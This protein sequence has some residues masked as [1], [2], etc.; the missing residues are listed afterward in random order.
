MIDPYQ[1]LGIPHG[2]TEEEIKKAYRKKAK[3]YHPDL[4]PDDPVAAQKMNEVNEAYDMLKNPEKYERKRAQEKQQSSY[5]QNYYDNSGQRSYGSGQS[6]YG[7]GQSS[8]GSGYGSDYGG[9]GYYSGYGGFNFE[10]FF[11][12]FG[13]DNQQQYGPRPQSNDPAEMVR[14]VQAI[15]AGR[16]TEAIRILS[17]MTSNQ[18]NARWYYLMALAYK[19]NGDHSQAF[20]MIQKAIQLEPGNQTY[21]IL[22]RQYSRMTQSGTDQYG[23]GSGGSGWPMNG[24]RIIGL[25]AVLFFVL[26]YLLRCGSLFFW[27]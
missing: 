3:E 23:Y 5:R 26:F 9:R 27:F 14:A 4:H 2:A 6:S 13:Y 18:R 11:R 20:S 19:G 12:G 7:S 1:V 15:N 22:Y 8:S 24:L 10:D 17:G 25:I 16:Y 21:Q